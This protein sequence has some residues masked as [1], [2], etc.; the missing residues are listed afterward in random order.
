MSERIKEHFIKTIETFSKRRLPD[1]A[2]PESHYTGGH[3]AEFALALAALLHDRGQSATI[4]ILIREEFDSF[5]D[6]R[7]DNTTFS[8]VFVGAFDGRLDITGFDETNEAF[9]LG[10]DNYQ[11]PDKWGLYSDYDYNDIA[12]TTLE[13]TY[14]EMQ[15]HSAPYDTKFELEAVK[16]CLTQLKNVFFEPEHTNEQDAI[17]SMN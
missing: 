3:C 16:R 9:E 14:Y 15:T 13:K 11:Q 8:H 12:F 5:E 4:S 7:L 17:L 10:C 1:I 6:D 2:D